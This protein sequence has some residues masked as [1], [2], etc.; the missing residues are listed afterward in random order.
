MLD[1]LDKKQH[2]FCDVVPKHFFCNRKLDVMMQNNKHRIARIENRFIFNAQYKLTAREQKVILYLIANVDPQKQERF[3]EQIISVKE[4][5]SVLK[6]DGKKWGGLYE[7]MQNFTDRVLDKKI[8]FPTDLK[9]DGQAFPGKI[10]WFQ[11]VTPIRNAEGGVSLRFLFAEDLRPFLLQLNEYAQINRLEAAPMKSGHAIRMFQIFK[12]QRDRMRRYEKV[13]QVTYGVEDLKAVLGIAGKYPRFNSFRQRVL[14]TVMNEINAHTSLNLQ[15][16]DYVR[17]GKRQVVELIFYISEKENWKKVEK[18]TATKQSNSTP[19]AEPIL[20]KLTKS[21]IRTYKM[22]VK[23]HI[24][25]GIAYSQIVPK[26][27]NGSSEFVGFEDWYLELAWQ[28]FES[29]TKFNDKSYQSDGQLKE[30]KA[31][32]FVNWFLKDRVFEQGDHFDRIQ[33]KLSNKKKLVEREDPDHWF[34][35]LAVKGKMASDLA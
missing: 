17:N 22:L 5:E 30:K 31:G 9:I 33:T 23:R 4:L 35:R 29:K 27:T 18:T 11:S 10:N 3:H 19:E 32:A 15:K 21:Q 20:D 26:I 12:A 14:D 34:E 6:D 7:E 2:F 1:F 8:R 24:V 13:S 16:I 28:I 25:P